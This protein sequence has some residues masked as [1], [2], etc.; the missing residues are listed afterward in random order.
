M[1]SAEPFDRPLAGLE[2]SSRPV[3]LTAAPLFLTLAG[4]AYAAWLAIAI[5]P[6]NVDVSWLL[7]VCDRLLAGERL[8]TDILETNPPFS[9]WLYMPFM[10]LEKL[11][12]IGAELWLTLGVVCL[13][14]ASLFASA[15]ILVRVDPVYRQPGVLWVLPAAVFMILCFLPDQFGQREQFA[16]IGILPW[17]ALQCARQRTPDFVAGS[18]AERILAG[19]SAAVMVMVKPPH[20][21]LALVLPSLCLAF[22]RRSPRL[23]FVTE[24]LVGAAIVVG[25]VAC[26][27]IFDR[28]YFTDILPLLGDVYL[29]IRAPFIDNLENWPKVVLLLSAAIVIAMGGTRHVHWDTRILLTSA[30]GLVIAFLLMG[31]GWPNHALPMVAI[32]VL[33][34]GLQLLR[35][36]DFHKAG[37]VRRAA[38]IFGC[39]LVLQTTVR[40]QY[41]ALAADN[42]PIERSVAAI[43]GTIGHPTI[44]SIAAQM[45]AAHPLTRLVDGRFISRHPG[46][47]MVSKAEKLVRTADDPEQKQRLETIRDRTIG[48]FAAEISARKPDIVLSGPE[49]DPAWNALMLS[50]KRIAA[51]LSDYRVLHTEPAITVYVRSTVSQEAEGLRRKTLW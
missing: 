31:K 46:A 1:S 41:I 2:L 8:N 49:A 28:A 50:D 29:P 18:L 7:V 11:T 48:E 4:A 36:G 15:R 38:L 33:A 21:A 39:V 47:W 22:Q 12:G 3:W 6:T 37:I 30:L 45:Q 5:V 34:S 16:L 9:I 19:L 32:T 26:I 51:V 13:G 43:R 42:G 27:A 25:Y 20:F 17:L 40:A 24:N 23:L 44:I 10:L 35:F 14:L